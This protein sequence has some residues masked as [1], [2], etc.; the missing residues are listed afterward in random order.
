MPAATHRPAPLE[1]RWP[2]LL[3]FLL[4]GAALASF[5]GGN[6]PAGGA[7]DAHSTLV[8]APAVT[9]TVGAGAAPHEEDPPLARTPPSGGVPG[10]PQESTGAS[11]AIE[12]RRPVGSG[13]G[14]VPPEEGSGWTPVP[15]ADVEVIVE[16][17][18]AWSALAGADG[19]A[20]FGGLPPGDWWAVARAEGGIGRTHP[21]V[22]WEMLVSE[23]ATSTWITLQPVVAVEGHVDGG[24]EGGPLANAE[25]TVWSVA[26]S[27]VL[28]LGPGDRP[29]FGDVPLSR[30]RSDAHGH[31][32]LSV[33]D[34]NR[35]WVLT[36]CAPNRAPAAVE[37]SGQ[38]EGVHL[39]LYPEA[40]VRGTVRG[41]E[42]QGIPG[43]TV[44]LALDS[45]LAMEATADGQGRFSIR[46]LPTGAIASVR[47]RVPE[48][49][50]S[51]EVE[52]WAAV[53][54]EEVKADLQLKAWASLDVRLEDPDAW[55]QM[56]NT[57]RLQDP[58]SW[59]E[60]L[61]ID[62][63]GRDGK[64]SET[65]VF[66]RNPN[67]GWHCG[68]VPAGEWWV[69][70]RPPGDRGFGASV[71]VRVLSGE[72]ALVLIPSP[73]PVAIDGT[74]ED[75]DGVPLAGVQIRAW[76]LAE[77]SEPPF[78][79]LVRASTG[80]DGS[81]SLLGLTRGAYSL[82][83]PGRVLG[84]VADRVVAPAAGVRVVALAEGSLRFQIAG[85]GERDPSEDL[86]PPHQLPPQ[87]PVM[88]FFR[89][90]GP[91]GRRCSRTRLV[92]PET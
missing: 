62:L 42:G 81:F 46:G 27:S 14:D 60:F 77:D 1:G 65:A 50:P 19:V 91:G 43:A 87:E 9:S 21:V 80:P 10:R 70:L 51:G 30:T 18:R 36:A 8:V 84:D 13:R 89:F 78:G 11:L 3:S 57:Q 33:P 54:G 52:V 71:R 79:T 66:E 39:V 53:P 25:V 45:P 47:A 23:K 41:P 29:P 69:C 55:M 37:V 12:V 74:L 76:P 48:L 16:D 73:E 49:E 32:R 82:D 86:P 6:A 5:P 15:G 88:A 17:G 75:E 83:L 7:R 20:H 31:F 58:A 26:S 56:V 85:A 67:G 34:A 59:P 64:I 68:Q 63:R 24:E 35:V 4:S 92:L 44:R 40:S 2:L 61:Q 22:D 38:E 72:E 28:V 90:V